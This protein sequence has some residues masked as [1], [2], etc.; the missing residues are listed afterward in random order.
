MINFILCIVDRFFKLRLDDIDSLSYVIE[1]GFLCMV[2]SFLSRNCR[3][4]VSRNFVKITTYL[5][6]SITFFRSEAFA[7]VTEEDNGEGQPSICPCK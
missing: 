4:Y 2:F 7:E 5:I 3:V 6:T 1:F